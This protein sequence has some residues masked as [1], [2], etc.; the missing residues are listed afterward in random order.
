MW[1]EVENATLARPKEVDT[2]SSRAY[3]YIRRNIT[4]VDESKN[5]ENVVPQHYRWE[6]TKV[7]R[8]TWD[9]CSQVMEHDTALNDVYAALTELA[10]II[11]EG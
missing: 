6:E 10:G 7:P 2:E 3:V 8:D 1:R 11:T 5:G 4:L 9:V